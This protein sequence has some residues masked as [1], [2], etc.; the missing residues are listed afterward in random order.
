MLYPIKVNEE[1][2]CKVLEQAEKAKE[3]ENPKEDK[4]DILYK[5][6]NSS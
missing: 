1:V 2:K 5:M 4:Q 6:R 3:G